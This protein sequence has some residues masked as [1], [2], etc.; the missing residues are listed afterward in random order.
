MFTM[1]TGKSEVHRRLLIE[2][3]VAGQ[4]RYKISDDYVKNLALNLFGYDMSQKNSKE[5][6]DTFYKEFVKVQCCLMRHAST[7]T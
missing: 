6:R 2:C 5:L 4:S 7:K 3:D 1:T